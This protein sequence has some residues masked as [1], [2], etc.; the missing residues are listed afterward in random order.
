MY[1]TNFKQTV[2]GFDEAK[3]Q[4]T[5]E[6]V[7]SAVA[8][9]FRGAKPTVLDPAAFAVDMCPS[10]RHVLKL[11]DGFRKVSDE[12]KT[13]LCRVT[14]ANLAITALPPL[15]ENISWFD[16]ILLL[17]VIERLPAP[18]TFL[19]E[20]HRRMARR[21]SELIITTPNAASLASR[22]MLA[23]ARICY[24]RPGVRLTSKDAV[25]TFKTLR[26]LLHQT[27]Y[28][29]TETRGL[30]VAVETAGADV[31]W[32]RA[33]LKL[34]QLLVKISPHLFADHICVRAR[35]TAAA[36]KPEVRVATKRP[37]LHPRMLGRIA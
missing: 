19:Q 36:H 3:L 7:R 13:K 24:D 29:V 32:T 20:L 35:P 10:G 28:Q 4:Q 34:N 17:G 33:L 23:I 25:F 8:K 21:G 5:W 2:F 14:D 9:R 26:A 6:S 16:E 30:P 15:P 12:L 37:T 18:Q 1:S 11:G 31:R 27:S 22:L